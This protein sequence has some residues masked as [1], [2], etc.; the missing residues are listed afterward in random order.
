VWQQPSGEVERFANSVCGI[1]VFTFLYIRCTMMR[2]LYSP[3]EKK[4]SFRWWLLSQANC[5]M[6]TNT[7]SI[8]PTAMYNSIGKKSF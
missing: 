8:E 4:T 1:R 2:G 3:L 6:V 5:E 7:I